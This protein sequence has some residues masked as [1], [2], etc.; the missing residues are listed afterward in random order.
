MTRRLLLAFLAL[1]FPSVLLAHDHASPH[2]G[3]SVDAG[4]YFV[5]LVLESGQ[6]K[7]FV[8]NDATE[9]PESMK[10]AKGTA[11]V[12]LGQQR[13]V[14]QLQPDQSEKDGNLLSGKL[15]LTPASG[16]RIVVQLQVPGQQSIVA[17]FA[18]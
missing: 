4:P 11:T 9:K 5:E 12:L 8:Y 16:M 6:I 14:A 7:I 2:G 10:A 3:R 17:R 15:A 18:Q 13:E 1:V